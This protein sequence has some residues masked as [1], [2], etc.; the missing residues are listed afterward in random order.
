MDSNILGNYVYLKQS[1]GGGG[2]N[3]TPSIAVILGVGVCW[4]Q[5]MLGM[6]VATYGVVRWVY[7]TKLVVVLCRFVSTSPQSI[8]A[9]TRMLNLWFCIPQLSSETTLWRQN[10]F[11]I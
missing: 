9:A 1:S 3:A 6:P 8:W 11:L 7:V 4:L 10:Y 5:V 2:G